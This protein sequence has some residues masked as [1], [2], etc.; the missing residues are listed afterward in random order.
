MRIK[1][2]SRGGKE[3]PETSRGQNGASYL[4]RNIRK[5]K[6]IDPPII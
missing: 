3:L 2:I 5:A 4:V 6:T 1:Q